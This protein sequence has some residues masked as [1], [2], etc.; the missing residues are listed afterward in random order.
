M[1]LGRKR[2]DHDTR[3]RE[4]EMSG[5]HGTTGSL[6]AWIAELAM[7]LGIDEM[8]IDRDQV[9]EASKS[10][11][12]VARAAAPFTLLLIGPADAV[13]AIDHDASDDRACTW[14]QETTGSCPKFGP[15]D[16]VRVGAITRSDRKSRFEQRDVRTNHTTDA[17]SPC[18]A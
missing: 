6:D 5:D 15:P 10:T 13:R 3:E 8:S 16:E 9:L 18:G 7:A 2:P 11:H 14:P 1:R 4:E 12:R 17:S